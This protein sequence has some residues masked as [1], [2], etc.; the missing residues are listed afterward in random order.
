MTATMLTGGLNK[1]NRMLQDQLIAKHWPLFI[2]VLLTLADDPSTAVRRRGLLILTDFLAK[3]PGR[4]L[5]DTGLAKVFE[6]AIFPTLAFLPSL[7]PD[8]E[9]VQ[10]LVP[11]YGALLRLADKQQQQQPTTATPAAAARGTK[12]EQQQPGVLPG[13][14]KIGLLDKV[15]REGVFMGYFHAKEHVRIVEVLC[16]QTAVILNEMGIHAVKHLKVS[17]KK[18]RKKKIPFT[19]HHFPPGL[20]NKRKTGP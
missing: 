7:T 19:F 14:A 5:H 8:D 6:D 4:T 20:A 11:A 1:H 3:F 12:E 15:L 13:G 10:L 17:R 18:K 2:P 16:Q 9:S